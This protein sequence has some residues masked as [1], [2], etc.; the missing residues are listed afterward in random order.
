MLNF[1][2]IIKEGMKVHNPNWPEIP[3][4]P[5][6]IL[7]VGGSGSGKTNALINLINNET[8]IYKTYLYAKDPYEAKYQLLIKKRESTGVKYLMI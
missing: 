8:Y 5:Y 2:Y 6:R 7:I 1:D 4:R 3:D